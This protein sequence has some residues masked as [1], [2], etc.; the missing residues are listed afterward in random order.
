[1]DWVGLIVEATSGQKLDAYFR[2]HIFGPLGMQDSGFTISSEQRARQ[3][4]WHQRQADGLLQ[5][6]PY[7]TPFTPEFRAGGG[8]LYSTAGDYMTFL[9]AMLQ[10]GAVGDARIL[11]PETV[12]LMGRNHIGD[13]E[14]GILKTTDPWR[15]VDVDFFPGASLK[16]GLGTM[17]NLQP[18]R[19]GRSAGSLTW[20]GLY[21]THYWIDPARRVTGLVMTQILPF[22]DEPAMRLYGQFERAVY[23]HLKTA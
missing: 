14:A 17:I 4:N 1:M 11:Q 8:G 15:S 6:Q 10:G 13:I 23:K 21:N 19:N 22:G 20:A 16:W 2:E 7:E 12:A 18:S 9:R 5:P 3:A